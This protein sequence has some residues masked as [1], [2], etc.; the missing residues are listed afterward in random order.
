MTD[1]ILGLIILVLVLAAVLYIYK[2]KKKGVKCVG[3]P[4]AGSCSSKKNG[5]GCH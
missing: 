5:T 4:H 2:E 3:C 1:I